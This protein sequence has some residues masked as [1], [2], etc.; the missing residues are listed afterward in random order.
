VRTH[1]VVMA[2]VVSLWCGQFVAQ[3][4]TERRHEGVQ[5]A[6]PVLIGYDRVAP[7]LDA[8]Y[9]D[10][11]A[12]QLSQ[13][14]ITTGNPNSAA[15]DA[16]QQS[17]QAAFSANTLDAMQNQANSQLFQSNVAYQTSL[18]SQITA[19]TQTLTTATTDLS[20]AT[21][22]KATA[23]AAVTE[24]PSDANALAA[25]AQAAQTL[26]SAQTA[27]TAA[28]AQVTALTSA[29]ATPALGSVTSTTPTAATNAAGGAQGTS[30]KFLGTQSV[31]PTIPSLAAPSSSNG[32]PTLPPTQQMDTQ[33]GLL[34]D[35]VM[36]LLS[37]FAQ[38]DSEKNVHYE[39]LRFYP[40]VTYADR[41][42]D[43]IRLEYEAKCDTGG[44]PTVM[45][46]YPRRAPV[47]IVGEKVKDNSFSLAG[48]LG[49]GAL[50]ASASYNREHLKMITALS[51]AS[52]ATG[53]GAGSNNFGWMLGKVMGDDTIAVGQREMYAL[54][55]LPE[56]CKTLTVGPKKV[57]WLKSDGQAFDAEDANAIHIQPLNYVWEAVQPENSIKALE[58][59]QSPAGSPASIVVTMDQDVDAETRITVNG[60]VVTRA[61]DNFARGTAPTTASSTPNNVGI[62]EQQPVTGG[63]PKGAWARLTEK[64]MVIVLDPTLYADQFPSLAVLS[65]QSKTG[66]L[67]LANPPKE[68]KFNGGTF[69]CDTACGSF[70]GLLQSGATLQAGFAS[71]FR[72]GT[73]ASGA[74]YV[75]ISIPSDATLPVTARAAQVVSS[76]DPSLQPWGP[77]SR[78]LATGAMG[79]A[80][81]GPCK[82]HGLVLLCHVWQKYQGEGFTLDVYD[83]MHGS[84]SVA[85]HSRIK[86]DPS[87]I[88]DRA[89]QLLGT[90]SP[91]PVLTQ[92]ATHESDGLVWNFSFPLIA[93]EGDSAVMRSAAGN[94]L[95]D[96]AAPTSTWAG[97]AP[98]ITC[99]SWPDP[100]CK[101]TFVVSE[102]YL[103]NLTDDAEVDFFPK[104][105][106]TIV[107]GSNPA[108]LYNLRAALLPRLTAVDAD[109]RHLHGANLFFDGDQ[110][111]VGKKGPTVALECPDTAGTECLLASV[112]QVKTAD[113]VY[114]RQANGPN[115]AVL[116]PLALTTSAGT[117]VWSVT[118]PVKV[119]ANPVVGKA[120][121]AAAVVAPA[122]KPAPS[123]TG[124]TLSVPS[125]G[126]IYI[127]QGK[128]SQ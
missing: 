102:R 53:F 94:L 52:Y 1:N 66:L 50:N 73:T 13:V 59:S 8:I 12:I 62:F 109:N 43:V 63:V 90:P 69:V 77:S 42:T 83:P 48:F 84:G 26:T 107:Y 6:A 55:A 114:L 126:N 113:Y 49:F 106:P 23:D 79:T 118:P 28:Q 81:L 115:G 22:Q 24:S 61:R 105:T 38:P 127:Y 7:L 54:I 78:L 104:K 15:L 95:L 112:P 17:F 75:V 37:T 70:P 116:Y 68:I 120:K 110:I 10:V 40:S 85:L 58:Y 76:G 46:L 123:S 125:S 71:V 91:V 36:R 57:E 121:A 101:L 9:E 35:R 33:I 44:T 82:A 122:V 11:A 19:A 60:V 51:Q 41:K 65:P 97:A 72:V 2:L 87:T 92:G 20:N 124:Q 4:K 32:A 80:P 45:D 108:F 89:P 39:L 117:S 67:D 18:L 30:A 34:W 56:G 29:R 103:S 96:D 74:D 99:L 111:Q 119:V 31:N 3:S 98:R 27:Q 5:A 47:N 88:A 64:K 25:Q 128:P 21:A 93:H 100:V 16:V 86:V 14:T